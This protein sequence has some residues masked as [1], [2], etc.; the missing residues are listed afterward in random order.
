MSS[1]NSNY[2]L[3]FIIFFLLFFLSHVH[4]LHFNFS[5]FSDDNTD[6]AYEGDAAP[7]RGSIELNAIDYSARVGRATYAKKVR[8]WDSSNGKLTDFTTRFSFMVDTRGSKFYGDGFAFFLAP[9]GSRIPPNSAGEFLGLLNT[10]TSTAN[11]NNQIVFVEFDSSSNSRWDPRSVDNHI[12]INLNSLFSAQIAPWNASLHSGETAYVSITY[13]ATTKNMTVFWTYNSSNSIAFLDRE[14]ILAYVVDLTKVLPEWVVVGFS[15]ATG[16]DKERH[17][18]RSWEFTSSLDAMEISEDNN[19]GNKTKVLVIALVVPSIV[20]VAMLFGAASVIRQRRLRARKESNHHASITGDLEFGAGPKKFSYRQLASATNNFSDERK[21][22]EGGFGCVYRGF[23]GEINQNVAVKRISRTSKQG[24]K[25]YI[26]E[27]KAISQLRHRNL[28]RLIGWCHDKGEFILVY[29]F[30]PN[31]SLDSHLFG[32]KPPLNWDTRY[33]ISL[34]LA[35]ALLYL[36]EEWE[37]C[38]VHRDIK[39]SNV[40]LDSNFNAKLGDFGLA[41]LMDHELGPKTTG[42][43]G[44]IGYL[45]PEYIHTGK[46]SKE[47]DVY[48]F[49]V[50]A[51]EMACGRKSLDLIEE[52][53]LE[54]GLLEWIWKLYG[55]GKL[56]IAVDESLVVKDLDVKVVERLMVVGLWCAHPDSSLR[57][58]VRQ[59]IQ[60]LK[61][62]AELPELPHVM[63]VPLFH[64]PLPAAANSSPSLSTSLHEGR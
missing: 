6:I 36:H 3:F 46:P 12:G 14:S 16:T 20:L 55:I 38:V 59:A 25:E 52:E 62:E 48:S 49:G 32:K 7:T 19:N 33:K 22:G 34:G 1:A 13:N 24:K 61:L 18:V 43:A 26:T 9:V 28:V 63:P 11:S 40:M 4:S 54:V 5:S 35:S 47:A 58:S 23:L 45:A 2:Q 51:L 57:P 64:L 56:S 60:V 42:V 10:T 29:E 17:V 30:M 53:S 44:T 27:V 39:S 21:L 31:G 37:Q 50:L 8:I 41:R 15:A